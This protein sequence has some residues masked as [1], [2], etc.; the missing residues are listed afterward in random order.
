MLSM[1]YSGLEKKNTMIPT[2]CLTGLL[3]LSCLLW[4]IGLTCGDEPYA[5]QATAEQFVEQICA[6]DSDDIFQAFEIADTFKSACPDPSIKKEWAKGIDAL[7]GKLGVV[8][9]H[10][11]IDHGDN[12]KSVFLYFD[13]AK[14]PAKIWVTFRG[15]QIGGLH[16][17]IWAEGYGGTHSYTNTLEKWLPRIAMIFAF[18]YAPLLIVLSIYLGEK[19]RAKWVQV[20]KANTV[21]VVKEWETYRE[22]QNPLWCYVLLEG[23]MIPVIILMGIIL[24]VVELGSTL[25]LVVFVTIG[26]IASSILPLFCFGFFVEVD[27]HFF[28][29]RLGFVG[30]RLL[31]I[32][33]DSIIS[34]ETTIFRPLRDFGGWGI[35][36]GGDMWAYFMSG[37]EGVIIITNRGEKYMVGSDIPERLVQVIQAKKQKLAN[38]K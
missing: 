20:K 35:R 26:L 10:E 30:F 24:S 29:L 25:I 18:V 28:T 15:T 1:M 7:F 8:R 3:I 17:D 5:I 23:S 21:F 2:R 9:Q 13:A 22:E 12:S 38:T 6:K 31:H 4:D 36:M 33:L 34:A 11:I 37:T 19:W 14:R 27:D 32:R 16:W